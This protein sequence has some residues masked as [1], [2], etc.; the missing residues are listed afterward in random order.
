MTGEKFW[1]V[2]KT[3]KGFKGNWIDINLDSV[4]LPDNSIIE[5]EAVGFHRNGVG[6]VAEN[7]QEEIILVKNYRYIN[8]FYSWEIPAGTIPPDKHHS[9]CII[10]EL[11]E[12][13]GCEVNKE[14]LVYIGNYYPSVGSSSQV[15]HGYY[16]RN[17]E[18]VTA[19]LDKNEILEAKWFSKNEI[20]KMIMDSTIKDGFSLVLLM[21]FM[22]L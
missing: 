2:I 19:E 7:K 16:A 8:D 18:Q 3:Q 17:V 21:R 4:K 13:A 1:K 10:E 12:E 20:K 11:R 14:D 15:F 9:E 5:F 6:I 22:F